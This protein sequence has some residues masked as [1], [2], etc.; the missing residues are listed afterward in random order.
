MVAFATSA[1]L[2]ARWRPLDTTET[3]RATVLLD[4][5]SAIIRAECAGIDARITAG[6]LGT[7]VAKLVAC[8]IVKRAMLTGS[9]G[10]GVASVQETAGPFSQGVTY[11]NPT[12]N[13]YLTKQERRLL[14]Y[15][16]QGA[17]T[18]DTAPTYSG[19]YPRGLGWDC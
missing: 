8:A 7:D 12:G 1:D 17:F 14:G 19:T 10:D 18:I 6:T 9:V 3:A 15:G 11:A 5:A 2:V 4:D 16:G 13:L